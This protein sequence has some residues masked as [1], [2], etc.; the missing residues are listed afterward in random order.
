MKKTKQTVEELLARRIEK[1]DRA[2][3][4]VQ[5]KEEY[6]E[7]VKGY[8]VTAK[9]ELADQEAQLEKMKARIKAGDDAK[10][11]YDRIWREW[12]QLETTLSDSMKKSNVDYL[13]LT[14]KKNELRAFVDSTRDDV[15]R[16]FYGFA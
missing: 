2:A 12:F 3:K 10:S 4:E 13:M 7:V 6:V 5:K 11:E 1:R 15:S 9:E 8:V 16:I 14:D